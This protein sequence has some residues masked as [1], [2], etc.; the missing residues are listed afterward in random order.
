MDRKEIYNVKLLL[1]LFLGVTK[2]H[3]IQSTS[4]EAYHRQKAG[5]MYAPNFTKWCASEGSG[6]L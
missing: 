5:T 1:L 6:N 4:K 2:S 3:Q